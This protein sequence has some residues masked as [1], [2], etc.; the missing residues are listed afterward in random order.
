[1]ACYLFVRR[2][3]KLLGVKKLINI[4]WLRPNTEDIISSLDNKIELIKTCRLV[5]TDTYHCAITCM[6]EEVPFILIGKGSDETKTSTDEK[7]KELLLFML[8]A[9]NCYYYLENI[10]KF[11]YYNRNFKSKIK[12]Q[13]SIQNDRL[14]KNIITAKERYIERVSEVIKSNIQ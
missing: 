6:R 1:M 14:H 5:I 4:K 10:M 7:K 3:A 2:V 8:Q 13:I 12:K 11:K 9:N